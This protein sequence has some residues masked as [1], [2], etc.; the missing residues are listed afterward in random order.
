MGDRNQVLLAAQAGRSLI[1]WNGL[2]DSPGLIPD[3]EA[4]TIRYYGAD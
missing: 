1:G 2:P 3:Q 4:K